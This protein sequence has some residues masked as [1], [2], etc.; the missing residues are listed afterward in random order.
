[1]SDEAKKE[2]AKCTGTFAAWKKILA[3][4]VRAFLKSGKK[5]DELQMPAPP[6]Q[7]RPT[8]EQMED[9]VAR[10]CKDLSAG[11]VTIVPLSEIM[12]VPCDCF[13]CRAD[14]ALAAAAEKLAEATEKRTNDE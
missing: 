6:D 11:G 5:H 2:D 13:R 4:K 1:M 12:P 8:M 10:I 7:D 14:R 9:L 3:D